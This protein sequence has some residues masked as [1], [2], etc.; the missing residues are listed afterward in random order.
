MPKKKTATASWTQQQVGRELFTFNQYS[1][2][3]DGKD[4]PVKLYI[5]NSMLGNYDSLGKAMDRVAT[6]EDERD[7]AFIYPPILTPI[8]VFGSNLAGRHGK[9]AAL[10]ARKYYGAIQGQAEGLQNR[11]YGIPTRDANFSN[12]TLAQIGK[13][14]ETF[15]HFTMINRQ[16]HFMLTPIGCGLAGYSIEQMWPLVDAL[17][18]E[19][20][21]TL[22]Q[23]WM[24]DDD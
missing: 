23:S 1:A 11:C 4:G 7:P 2:V 17:D 13:S 15:R 5:G 12:L 14:L 9:G 22:T 19:T 18:L 21:V 20:N 8:F 3:R 6:I 24:D 16:M 10:D